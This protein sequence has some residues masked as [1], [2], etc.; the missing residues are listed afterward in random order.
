MADAFKEL[1]N[2]TTLS[3]STKNIS[4]KGDPQAEYPKPNYFYQSSMR[5][6]EDHQLSMGG[7][8]PDI[9]IADIMATTNRNS[10]DYTEAS[11]KVT[12]SGHV[13][14]FDDAGWSRKNSFKTR[15]WYWHRDATRWYYDYES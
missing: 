9:D 6:L 11:V 13:L 14:I 15:K 1:E 10:S 3:Q 12:K 4:K 8:D 7:G 2:N 5:Q